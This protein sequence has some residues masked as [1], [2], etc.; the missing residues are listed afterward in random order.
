MRRRGLDY[1]VDDGRK[2]PSGWGW[3]G[4]MYAKDGRKRN[5]RDSS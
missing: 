3:D 2:N 4:V 5:E 1:T